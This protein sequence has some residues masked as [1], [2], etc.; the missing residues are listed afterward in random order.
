VDPLER[1]TRSSASLGDTLAQIGLQ[2]TEWVEL[3]IRR[4]HEVF[5]EHR[6]DLIVADY[7]PG[8]V[9][10]ARDRVPC[11]ASGVGFTV[12]PAELREFPRLH[13]AAPILYDESAICSAVNSA[14][15]EFQTPPIAFLPEALAGDAQCACTLPILDPYDGLRSEPVL[16][17]RLDAPIKRPRASGDEIFC[18][19]REAP[20]S[21]R[22][23]E[24]AALLCDLPGRVVAFIP[25]LS[26]ATALRLSRNGII[27]LDSPAKL[28]SQ[29]ARSRMVIHFGGH[30][31]ASAALLSATPQ[32]ILSFD[33]EKLLIATSLERLGVAQHY[34]YYATS[35]ET[36]TAA[37]LTALED[38]A[39]PARAME[40]ARRY[41]QYRNCDVEAAIVATCL[42]LAG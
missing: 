41:D 20:R 4:W 8:A 28:A 36:V 30:G 24:F 40:V 2:S 32:V 38:L 23:D 25:G 1:V 29:L 35:S 9:L 22:L 5:A 34:D 18:Y 26:Q 3:Q 19:L 13:A 21:T 37:A 42:R 11:V 7:A 6:P 12:P 33:I 27:L 17:P 16:G 31:I 15:A 39:L 10:A 14:L